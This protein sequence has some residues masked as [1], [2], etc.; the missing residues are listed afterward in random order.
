MRFTLTY[1][2]PL[3][4]SSGGSAQHKHDIRRALHPQLRA[5]WGF[6]PLSNV[7]DNW[8][9]QLTA[10][11]QSER[12]A[13]RREVAGRQFVVLVRQDLKL[14]AELDV[15][16]L[17]PDRPGSIL[18]HADIDNR[19]KVLF[20]ALRRPD[21]PQELPSCWEP[22]ADELPLYCLL[23]D[24]RLITR[25]NVEADRLLAPSSADDVSLF[26]RVGIRA[27][28]PTYASLQIIY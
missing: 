26:I 12:G 3:K 8:V 24:D 6:E 11:G 9:E 1:Q 7:K 15:L 13:A 18:Q 17:R 4:T 23:D 28:S 22:T 27:S 10:P 16:L 5:L 25:V 21:K 19:L 14:V 20:D 2:G